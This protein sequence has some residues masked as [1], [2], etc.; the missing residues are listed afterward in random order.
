MQDE[1]TIRPLSPADSELTEL[2]KIENASFA[3]DAYQ[4]E[5]FRQVYLK[6][7]ELA[8]VAEIKGQIAGYMMTRRLPDR[9]NIFS[10]AVAPAY[11]RRDVGGA[12][13]RYTVNRLNEWGIARVELEVRKTNETG[14]L[15]WTRMGFLPVSIIPNFYD[16]GSEALLMR[17]F[18]GGR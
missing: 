14:T 7:S 9:G 17:K 15:F 11:R 2:V 8:I 5:D 12:L 18:I 4:I 13:F 1:I 6:C 3:T 16:D 10:V